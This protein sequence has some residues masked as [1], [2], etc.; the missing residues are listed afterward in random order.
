[1][2]HPWREFT[3]VGL[4]FAFTNGFFGLRHDL[5][6]TSAVHRQ[7]LEGW[8]G[9]FAAVA[10]VGTYSLALA[11]DGDTDV[12]GTATDVVVPLQTGVQLVD[13]WLTQVEFDAFAVDLNDNHIGGRRVTAV[14]M[15]EVAEC[16]DDLHDAPYPVARRRSVATYIWAF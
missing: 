15:T 5:V 16:A 9:S 1:M 4:E 7:T 13:V 12:A 6:S 10:D 8:E 14:V 2:C 11:V 3:T